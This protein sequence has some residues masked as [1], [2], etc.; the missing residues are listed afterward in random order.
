MTRHYSLIAFVSAD[1][2]SAGHRPP[3][4]TSAVADRWHIGDSEALALA[5]RYIAVGH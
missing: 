3:P 5:L 1:Q 2:V 4:K